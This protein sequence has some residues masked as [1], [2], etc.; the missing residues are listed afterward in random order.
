MWTR[1]AFAIPLIAL[2][3][4]GALA[5]VTAWE[6]LGDGLQ[7]PL[8]P[9]ITRFRGHDRARYHAHTLIAR[10]LGRIQPEVAAVQW[11]RAAAHVRSDREIETVTAG[12][13]AAVARA[14]DQEA[15]EF[16]CPRLGGLNE[17]QRTAM[18][19]A[20]LDCG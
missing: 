17:V 6:I 18:R 15:A 1:L 16:V 5:L 7:S 11:V 9:A 2:G 13:T 10:V 8:P 20:R 19:R 14:G 4:A 3:L 12:L